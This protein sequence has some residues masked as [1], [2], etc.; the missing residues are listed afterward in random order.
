MKSDLRNNIIKIS[1]IF[2]LILLKICLF[3]IYLYNGLII[4]SFISHPYAFWCFWL[5]KIA[6]A[7]VITFLCV[8]IHNK[9]GVTTFLIV[10]DIWIEANLVYFRCNGLFIDYYA[11]SM[12]GNMN[13]VWDSVKIFI[14]SKDIIFALLT[15]AIIGMLYIFPSSFKQ[16]ERYL[17]LIIS[18]VMAFLLQITANYFHYKTEPET[19][20]QLVQ[21]TQEQRFKAWCHEVIPVKDNSVFHVLIWDICD[22]CTLKQKEYSLSDDDIKQI[23]PFIKSD[24]LCN[25]CKNKFIIIIVE[26]ME[27][28]VVQPDITP[29]IYKLAYSNQSLFCPHV[30]TQIKQGTSSDGQLIVNTGILPINRGAW[31]FLYSDNKFPALTSM[32]NKSVSLDPSDKKLW[33]KYNYIHA[34]GIKEDIQTE[35]A[36]SILFKN[37]YEKIKN[38]YDGIWT[39]TMSTHAP[40]TFYNLKNN[41]DADMPETMRA[42]I[43]S[44][45]QLDCAIGCLLDSM[46]INDYMDEY[47]ILITGDHTILPND[48]R[49]EFQSYCSSHDIYYDNIKEYCPLIIHSPLINDNIVISSE[50]L[51]MD[52]YPTML[53]LLKCQSVWKGFGIDLLNYNHT[54]RYISEEKANELS[55]KIIRAYYFNTLT[56]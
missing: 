6:A 20:L 8:F 16:R 25:T 47:T 23:S 36:D 4:S 2:C 24:V 43:N 7:M 19:K 1:G 27:G 21:C 32:V 39:I 13:G 44:F 14:F 31:S 5:P 30:K 53:N 22:F 37:V 12:T 54:Q 50:C 10:L 18:I 35:T 11:L 56:N 52:I 28:W 45:N 38:G 49:K 33:N 55:D 34:F 42:Y 29:N 3:N 40:F 9:L 15:G 17:I 46:K 41:Y 51:Q 26:S 48:T